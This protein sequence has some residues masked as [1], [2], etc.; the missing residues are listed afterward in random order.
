MC[1]QVRQS[2]IQR[3][4]LRI[5]VN[6]DPEVTSVCGCNCGVKNKSFVHIAISYS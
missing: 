1:A 4:I 3:K 6:T 5:F 2:V